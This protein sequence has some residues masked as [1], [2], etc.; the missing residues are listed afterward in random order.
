VT[1]LDT[2]VLY[3]L[4]DA[5]DQRHRQ[6]TA[7]YEESSEELAT[8]P[9]VLAEVDHLAVAK[10]GERAVRAFR[11]DAASG[12]YLVEWWGSAAREAVGVAERYRDLG[13]SLTDASLVVL[14]ARLDTVAI[15]TFDERH[16][17]AMRPVMGA[18]AF[19]LVPLDSV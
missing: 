5:R 12:A 3:A 19:R 11:H 7:W 6:A 4:L 2:S 8:T 9:L 15:A 10:A 13:P 1:I 14:A 18:P 16:F 17:R